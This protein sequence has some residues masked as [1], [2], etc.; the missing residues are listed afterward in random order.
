MLVYSLERM[1][2][3]SLK[4]KRIFKNIARSSTVWGWLSTAAVPIPNLQLQTETRSEIVRF[5][6][7]CIKFCWTDL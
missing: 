7:T 3:H 1:L 2:T 5:T 4:S 6:Q